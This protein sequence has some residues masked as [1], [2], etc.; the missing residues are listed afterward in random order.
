M[1][2]FA[3]D[4][5]KGLQ[6]LANHGV[7]FEAARLAFDDPFAVLVRGDRRRDTAR[8]ACLARHGAR[9][10]PCGRPRTARRAGSDHLGPTGNHGN[11]DATMKRTGK[12][13]RKIDWSRA[14]AMSEAERHAASMADPDARPMTDERNG[15]A[16]PGCPRSVSSAARSSSHKSSSRPRSRFRLERSVIG[17]KDATS[18]MLQHAPTCV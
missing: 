16:R 6:N 14:D 5:L 10:P 11:D 2:E 13:K 3:W 9:P 4:D 12:G 17:S 18:P 1:H 8:I 15:L 7:S